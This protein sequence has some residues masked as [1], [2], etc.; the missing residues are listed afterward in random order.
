MRIQAREIF[1]KILSLIAGRLLPISVLRALETISQSAL[2][3]GWSGEIKKETQALQLL[4]KKLKINKIVALD[5]GG[6]VGEWTLSLKLLDEYAEIHVFEPSKNTFIQLKKNLNHLNDVYL[7]Q[8]ALGNAIGQT[9][10]FS[11]SE[12]SPLASLSER[13]L[14][15]LDISFSYIEEIEIITLNSWSKSHQDVLPNVLKIDVEGHE[16]Q[17]LLGATEL[18][19]HIRIIQFEFGGTDIDS[20]VFFRDFWYFFTSINFKIYRL[21]PRGLL[22]ILSYSENEEVFKYS[23]YYAVR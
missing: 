21:T 1:T 8:I 13:K 17:V 20:K 19:P 5:V 18:L 2:G 7:Y 23:N 12:S 10:L 16:L 11:N 3:K 14:D 6:N 9:K 22:E 15:Y 4:T